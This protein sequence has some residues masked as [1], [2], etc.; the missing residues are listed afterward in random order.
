MA[1]AKCDLCPFGCEGPDGYIGRCRVRGNVDGKIELLTY[2]HVTTA[3][4]G[5]IEQKP[6]YHF[7]L[8]MQVLSIGSSGCNMFCSYCVPAGTLIRTPNGLIPIEKIE[9]G[10]AVVAVDNSTAFPQL[11]QAHVDHVANREVEELIELQ[12]DGRTIL[13]TSEHPVLTRRGWV[14]AGHLTEDDEVLCDKTY[15]A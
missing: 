15:S 9:D 5:P 6:I 1:Q 4:V 8:G 12:A 10:D 3:I 7:K 13:L 14:E 11:V 2:G